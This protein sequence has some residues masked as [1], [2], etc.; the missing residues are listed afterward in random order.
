M[1]YFFDFWIDLA[2]LI[3]FFWIAVR[4]I[5]PFNRMLGIACCIAITIWCFM[6]TFVIKDKKLKSG[7]KDESCTVC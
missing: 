3:F 6:I 1:R 2:L 4:F 5:T 7:G